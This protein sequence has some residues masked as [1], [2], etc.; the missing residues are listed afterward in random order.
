MLGFFYDPEIHCC[1]KGCG[2]MIEVRQQRYD[3]GD[4]SPACGSLAIW[5]RSYCIV[6]DISMTACTSLVLALQSVSKLLTWLVSFPFK[7]LRFG[8]CFLE[9]CDNH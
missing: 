7:I 1:A 5:T 2:L 8:V 9:F 6:C 4:H 3:C